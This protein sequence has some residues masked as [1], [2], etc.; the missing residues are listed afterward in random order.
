MTTT[1]DKVK[2]S[3]AKVAILGDMPYLEQSAPECLAAHSSNV[4]ACAVKAS[5]AVNSEHGAADKA[6][7]E[8]AGATYIDT[9]KWFCSDI[10]E[11]IIGTMVVYQ[12]QYHITGAYSRY[13]SGVV[14]TSLGIKPVLE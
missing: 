9:T 10:C 1:I 7:A 14:A 12:N 4:Q 3:G 8:A 5:T 6:T 11:P 13:L 2:K